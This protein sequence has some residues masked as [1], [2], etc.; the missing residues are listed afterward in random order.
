M[1]A[2]P[3]PKLAMRPMLPADVPLLA[4]IFRSSIEEL[5]A[6]DY[7]E[8]QREAWSAAADDEQAFGARLAGALTLV[9]TLDGAAI[10]FASLA[11]E[12]RFDMLYVHPA[13]SGLGAANMLC[14]ALEKLAA[15]RGSKELSVDASDS[16]RGF[17][18]RRGFAAKTRNTVML[19]G[20]WLANT[21]MVK[22]LAPAAPAG[23]G[24]KESAS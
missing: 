19:A 11:D 21:T 18:E 24:A 14:D 23:G 9:A 22:R 16:A 6:D 12:M 7:T 17:F 2:R 13:A 5:S 10:G 4:E 20:E 8:A 3:Q 1:S 15:S